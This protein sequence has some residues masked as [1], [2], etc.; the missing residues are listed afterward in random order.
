MKKLSITVLSLLTLSISAQNRSITFDHGSW[1]E[2]KEKA[3]KENKLIFVDAFTTWCGPCKWMAANVFTNDTVADYFNK[4]FINAKIDMEK[5]EGIELA[6]QYEVQCYPNLLFIDGSGNLVHR[7]AGSMPAGDFVALAE[8]S[9]DP[10][11][12]FAYYRD[13]YESKKSNSEFLMNYIDVY[14]STCLQPKD[15]VKTYFALQKDD[16]LTSKENWNMIQNNTNDMNSREF[17]YLV[18][19]KTKFVSLYGEKDVNSKIESVFRST[20][21]EDIKQKD[22]AKY[23]GDVAAITALKTPNGDKI[24]TDAEMRKAK[25]K[26]DW[27]AYTKLAVV[28]VDKY[29]LNDGGALNSFA[30][31]FYEHASDKAAMAKAEEWAKK[32]V[33]LNMAYANLDTYASVLFKNGKKDLALE[34]VEKAIRYAK[35]E[36]MTP[37]DYKETSALMEK[38]KAMK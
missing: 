30:W 12:R 23:N 35:S 16:Q 8:T 11:K 15:A 21:N 33:E 19:N 9:K 18:L 38:I 27:D 2:L 32:S 37:E 31:D 6:K 36:K 34:T 1:A 28:N 29:Y 10:N 4:N 3:K 25:K 26:N 17:I 13:N 5:G 7:K 14:T 20:L 22:E 24:I